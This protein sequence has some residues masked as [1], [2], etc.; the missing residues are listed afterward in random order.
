MFFL[1]S[2]IVSILGLFSLSQGADRVALVIGVDSYENLPTEAQLSVAVSD[3]ELMAKTLKSLDPPFDVDLQTNVKQDDVEE[4]LDRFIDKS[5]G[6]TCA[7]IYFAGHGVEYHGENFLLVNDTDIGKI[8][9]DVPRMKR[10]LG[11]EALSMQAMVDSLDVTGAQVKV[12]ILD[13]CRDNPLEAEDTSGTRSLVGASRGLA[14][15]TPPSGTLIAYSADAGQQA[16]DGLFTAVLAEKMITPGLPLLQV[17]AATREEV[18]KVSSDLASQ[19]KGVRHEPAEYTKLNLAGTKFAF[20]GKT[21][22]G[23]ESKEMEQLRRELENM[24]KQMESGEG[25][26]PATV[27][28]EGGEAGQSR[29]FSGV[30]MVWIPAGEFLM[31]SPDTEEGRR[32]NEQ[33]HRVTLSK[34]FWMARYECTQSQWVKVKDIDMERIQKGSLGSNY[35]INGVT[36]YECQ[37]WVK[38]M[39]EKFPPSPGWQWALPT[40]AQWEYACRAGTTTVFSFGDWLNVDLANVNWSWPYGTDDTGKRKQK[41]VFQTIDKVG[42]LE[43]NQWGLY[44]MHGNV[45]EWCADWYGNYPDGD[46]SDPAGPTTG[47]HR[48]VRGGRFGYGAV[49]ARSAQRKAEKPNWIG[50]HDGFRPVIV[51]R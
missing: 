50:Y 43:A 36:W 13:A 9:A 48:V 37:D 34:G 31:G 32:D 11:N 27:S 39:N 46:A 12:V 51:P 16:N 17:F 35:P 47:T 42:G 41:T 33:Q 14:Q 15:V 18:L 23:A 49:E 3:A 21:G 28:M 2:C 24:R 19:S 8:S 5:D 20:T 22:S 10:R 26:L 30:E 38:Q 40:E 7:L 4:A 6:A 44:D 29:D 45:G 25:T 1:R